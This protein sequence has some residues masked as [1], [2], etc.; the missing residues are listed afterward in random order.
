MSEP[1]KPTPKTVGLI[2]WTPDF[3]D[4]PKN[5][6]LGTEWEDAHG[7][8]FRRVLHEGEHVWYMTSRRVTASSTDGAQNER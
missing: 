7:H 1:T 6:P 3:T 8:V 5:P 4:A 2:S